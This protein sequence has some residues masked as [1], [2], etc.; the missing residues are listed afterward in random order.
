M[1]KNSQSF[2]YHADGLGS[3]T[4]IT[5]QT[6]TVVQR[7]AY[8]SFG[9]IESQLDPNFSQAYTFTAREIDPEIQLYFYRTRY[10][11]APNGRFIQ[12]DPVGIASG[13]LNLYGYVAG[14]PVTLTDPTGEC[15]WCLA[16]AV[17]ILGRAAVGALIG[18]GTNLA[19][20]LAQNDGRLECLDLEEVIY[21]A[22]VN[23]AVSAGLGAYFGRPFWQYYPKDNPAYASRFLTRGFGFSPPYATGKQAMEKLS[24]PAY[25]PA[26]AVRPVIE[27]FWRP[28]GGA[29]EV[30]RAYNQPGGGI[31]FIRK[32]W[33]EGP[34]RLVP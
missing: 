29:G 6:G 34:F 17:N 7:Y 18:G 33:P 2:Y 4:E 22:V 14:R 23:G 13:D 9:K 28:I 21:S 15:P 25:N 8:S 32:A 16:Y 1:E 3:I 11:D 31:E 5:N 19:V 20:Q 30:V 10:Y 12:E 24:L 26:T 27:P